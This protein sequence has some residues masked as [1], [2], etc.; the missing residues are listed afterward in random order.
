MNGKVSKLFGLM[1][2]LVLAVTLSGIGLLQATGTASAIT[3]LKWVEIPTPDEDD[4]QLFPGSD[5]GPIAVSPDGEILF[6]A[7]FETSA[8]YPPAPA[9]AGD[10]WRIVK[11]SDGGYT[12]KETGFYDDINP[13]DATAIVDIVVS[14]NWEYDDHLFVATQDNVYR[15]ADRGNNFGRL[16]NDFVATYGA[17]GIINCMDVGLDENNNW[18]VVIGSGD[19]DATPHPWSD[20]Y[21]LVYDQW[22]PQR[23]DVNLDTAA[24]TFLDAVLDVK[25]SPTYGD[26]AMTGYN[27]ILA[28]V[29]GWHYSAP[30]TVYGASIRGES[31][32]VEVPGGIG[33]WG[34]YISDGHFLHEENEECE[35]P[36]AG[37]GI[38]AD[39]A[40]MAFADDWADV[41]AV[42]VGL[43]AYDEGGPECCGS[44][45]FERGDVFRVN[46]QAGGLMQTVPTI[47]LDVTGDETESN[48]WSL[49][50]DGDADDAFILA[51]LR[52]MDTSGAPASWKSGVHIS[53]NGGSGWV[54]SFKPPSGI[55]NMATQVG[56]PEV[57]MAP[58]FGTSGI[59]YT[60]TWGGFS[61][62]W[63][64]PEEGSYWNGRGLLDFDTQAITSIAVSPQY[65]AD[66]NMFMVR[67]ETLNAPP[68]PPPTVGVLWET[69]DAGAHWECILAMNALFPLPGVLIQ[70][71]ELPAD[72]PADDTVMVT[73]TN[74]VNPF[75]PQSNIL[76]STDGGNTWITII[77][78]P[79]EV[80]G[81]GTPYPPFSGS[82][83][84]VV[85]TDTV[86]IGDDNGHV[87]YTDNGGAQWHECE[88]SDITVGDAITSL[89][90]E[91]GAL[92]VGT[93]EGEAFICYDWQDDFA[94]VRIG[95]AVGTTDDWTYVAFD[96]NYDLNDIVYCGL[97]DTAATT[98]GEIWRFDLGASIWEQ[99]SDIANTN[100]PLDWADP[101]ALFTAAPANGVDPMWVGSIKCGEEGTLYAIDIQNELVWRS[102]DPRE[103]PIN[104]GEIPLWEPLGEGLGWPTAP[105]GLIQGDL[106]VV[107]GT[108][109]LF[110]IGEDDAGDPVIWQYYDTLT[111][112]L[113][114]IDLVRPADGAS[115]VGTLA[116]DNTQSC[117]VLE[118]EK[119]EGATQY[120]WEI[121]LDPQFNTQVAH[122]QFL[123]EDLADEDTQRFTNGEAL[124]GCLWPGETYYWHVRVVLPFQSPWSE[125]WSF[126]TRYTSMTERPELLTPASGAV[127]VSRTPVLTWTQAIDADSYEVILGECSNFPTSLV[128]DKTGSNALT[129][130]AYQ[131]PT[132]LKEGTNY[133]WQVTA[134][135]GSTEVDSVI[136][137]FTTL[138]VPPEP[139]EEGTPYWVWV[140]IG[141][142][143]LMLVAVIVLIVLTKKA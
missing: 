68:L 3:A 21:L 67:Q 50:V 38:V 137:T 45:N 132:T 96:A 56:R 73:G 83:W 106:E 116:N 44:N 4:L 101:P 124:Q 128:V 110:A 24:G 107:T 46:M 80:G 37:C 125:T 74:S 94:I 60:G 81:A 47:D 11:S 143:A 30:L 87:L 129:A 98:N 49:A 54:P 5:V 51:G 121:A 7:V 12:W 20:V 62:F 114:P 88:D 119:A 86:F 113:G 52:H 10:G 126:T 61:G 75:G 43:N 48:I 27:W 117:L 36:T 135:K 139:E 31:Q 53:E 104:L 108:N 2:V 23:A 122:H 100:Q 111:R 18:M 16:G 77:H 102:T 26:E 115:G 33:N 84:D 64:S 6:A 82:S 14:P 89:V 59:S 1:M 95:D 71:V 40:R 8:T 141:V 29:L 70:W 131:V 136:G 78:G 57:I 9:P 66:D 17:G 112:D 79:S 65:S 39:R 92:L 133:C 123:G 22:V 72:W 42:F 85:D 138:T 41:Q 15:S 99:I 140:V 76:R 63:V 13:T 34:A 134:I 28:T 97:W 93:E 90:E 69:D 58:D 103:N 19:V 127:N 142:S 105:G 32:P 120:E 55:E 35:T 25:F 109:I 118:W 130:T 91:D